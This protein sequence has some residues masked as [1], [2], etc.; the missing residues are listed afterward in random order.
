LATLAFSTGALA[1]G[2]SRH[3]MR[4]RFVQPAAPAAAGNN[5]YSHGGAVQTMPSVYISYWG[6]EWQ[7]GFSTGAYSSKAA[8]SYI[9]RFFGDVGGSGWANSTSQY[10]QGVPVGTSSCPS[11]APVVANPTGQL[12]GTWTDTTPVP[13]YPSAGDIAR[14]ALRLV[15]ARGYDANATYMVFTP[16][17]KSTPGF[18]WYFCAWHDETTTATGQR[19]AYANMP[20][21]PNA[22]S[23]C[24]MNY[25]NKSNDSF[26]HGYFDGFSI[27]GG[28]EYAE[29]E[30]DPYTASAQGWLDSAGGENGDKSAWGQGLGPDPRSQNIT[31]GGQYYAAQPLWSNFHNGCVISYTKPAKP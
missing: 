13:R 25:V 9:N 19:V 18:G 22:G 16:S 24:G 7:R 23:G 21:Q 12:R 29:A 15:T 5:L 28:H 30:T 4:T 3:Y 10:C 27:V 26:G 1:S 17:G 8:Q 6:V 14:A 2:E 11:G 20:Y 31:L